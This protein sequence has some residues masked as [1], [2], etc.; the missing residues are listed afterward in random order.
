MANDGG[1]ATTLSSGRVKLV[2]YHH[3]SSMKVKYADTNNDKLFTYSPP[4]PR[5]NKKDRL[6]RYGDSHVKDKTAGRTSYL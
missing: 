4:G 3:E 2:E 6:S 5:L 1:S